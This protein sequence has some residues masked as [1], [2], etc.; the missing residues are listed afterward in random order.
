MMQRALLPTLL[1]APLL[2]AGLPAQAQ[3][4]G[5]MTCKITRI[6]DGAGQCQASSESHAFVFENA[7]L[8][9]RGEGSVTLRYGGKAHEAY[10]VSEI[11]PLIWAEGKKDLQTLSSAGGDHAIW[12]SFDWRRDRAVLRFMTCE[13]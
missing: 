7:K 5:N 13:E 6:C 8:N 12:Q 1:A 3:F 10:S 9:R 11:G 2:A 4:A